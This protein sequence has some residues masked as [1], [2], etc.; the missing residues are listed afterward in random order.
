M[1]NHRRTWY[2][3]EIN[4]RAHLVSWKRR[5]LKA[6]LKKNSRL[7]RSS[8]HCAKHWRSNLDDD[9]I[10]PITTKKTKIIRILQFTSTITENKRIIFPHSSLAFQLALDLASFIPFSFWLRCQLRVHRAFIIRRKLTT[11]FIQLKYFKFSEIL[12]S[13]GTSLL[14]INQFSTDQHE[15]D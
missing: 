10:M 5:I 7:S 6:K 11:C 4:S 3:H 8:H 1:A 2:T 12:N 15:F 9:G 13:P 14:R